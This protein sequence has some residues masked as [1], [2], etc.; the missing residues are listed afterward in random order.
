MDETTTTTS[1]R[2]KGGPLV[3]HTSQ[4]LTRAVTF[5]FAL[6]ATEEQ[7]TLFAKCNGAR[8]FAFNHH[9]ARVKENLDRRSAEQDLPVGPRRPSLS[10]SWV[11]FVNEFNA[12]KNG[13][14]DSSPVNDDGTRGLAWR[15]EVPGDVFEC[16]SVDAAR[17]LKNWSD[18]KRGARTGAPVGFPRFAAKSRTTPSFRLR[19]KATPGETQSIRFTDP[20]HL[21]LSKI[22]EVRVFG[23]TRRVRRMIDL[24]RFH[25]Y[26]ATIT[27]R[28]GRWICSLN[29]VAAQ[30][31]P[32][33]R[34]PKDR[35]AT[36]VGIDRGVTSLAVVADADGQLLAAFE[37]V[38]ELRRAH[39][40]LVRAQKTLARATPGSKG[41]ARA[42]AR[43]NKLHRRVANRRRHH[44]HQVTA[45]VMKNCTS[46]VLEDLNVAGMVRNHRLARSISDAAM[47]ELGRQ[48]LYQAPWYGVEVTLADRFFASSKIC[49]GCGAKKDRLDLSTRVYACAHC[50]LVIDRDHNAAVNLARWTPDANVST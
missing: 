25:V 39:E 37:G 34:H 9:L 14:L 41:R 35:H 49:S 31:H 38:N 18:S 43:L 46:V 1:T 40:Q 30:F 21:R 36:P 27:Q 4:A 13:Q 28:G 42:R 5:Q 20:A 10:W 3:S 2:S 22:G 33:R 47:G 6:D 11:S 44:A 8:R 45:W 16:A 17:A 12:W 19:N 32:E 7:R 26:S 29:G 50:G 15:R 24:G 48:I 23:P